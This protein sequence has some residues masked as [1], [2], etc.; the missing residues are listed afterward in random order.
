[1]NKVLYL[2]AYDMYGHDP[3]A[4]IT[5]TDVDLEELDSRSDFEWKPVVDLDLKKIEIESFEKIERYNTKLSADAELG[6]FED[7]DDPDM[8]YGAEEALDCM[9]AT[10]AERV[11][12]ITHY[13]IQEDNVYRPIE[14]ISWVERF[15]SN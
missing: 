2:F 13:F 9:V 15:N 1:M 3:V 12:G 8:E 4:E 5:T 14:D 10:I 7:P 6:I 11:T